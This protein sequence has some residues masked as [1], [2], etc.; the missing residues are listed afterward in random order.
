MKKLYVITAMLLLSIA[1][2]AQ[3]VNFTKL[4]IKSGALGISCVN[5]DVSY[6][7][8]ELG[9]IGKTTDGG[10][11]WTELNSSQDIRF[12]CIKFLDEQTG[13]VAGSLFSQRGYTPYEGGGLIWKTTN[14]GQTWEDISP[15]DSISTVTGIFPIDKDT[16][17]MYLIDSPGFLL[18]STNGGNN[19]DTIFETMGMVMT[20]YMFDNVGYMLVA[21]S[22]E[23]VYKT[24]DY[25]Q[26]WLRVYETTYKSGLYYQYLTTSDMVFFHPDTVYVFAPDSLIYTTDGFVTS[27]KLLYP[28]PF[29]SWVKVKMFSNGDYCMITN[30]SV[31]GASFFGMV[32]GYYFYDDD[33]RNLTAVDGCSD[34]VF[35]IV[36]SYGSMYT[37]LILSRIRT[38][39]V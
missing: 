26:T 25:G 16:L 27:E 36:D 10:K 20:F 37:N 34:S 5:E 31:E 17:Y 3:Q 39:Q 22:E 2:Q 11:T 29:Y 8:G 19:W 21:F 38:A 14:G 9:Y 35:Y 30:R 12:Q 28:Y 6:I 1:G 24:T 18:K 4:K 13:F 7:C 33:V 15:P 23:G 32:K